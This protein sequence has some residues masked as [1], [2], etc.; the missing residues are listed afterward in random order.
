M[1]QFSARLNE[2]GGS[3]EPKPHPSSWSCWGVLLYVEERNDFMD[4]LFQPSQ[5][6]K[7]GI[8]DI[9]LKIGSA[10]SGYRTPDFEMKSICYPSFLQFSTTHPFNK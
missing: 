8:K 2:N 5:L 4:L 3:R 6:E 1:V 7:F 9:V 10:C